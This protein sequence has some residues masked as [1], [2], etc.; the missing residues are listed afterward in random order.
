MLPYLPSLPLILVIY[1][2]CLSTG[3]FFNTI[4]LQAFSHLL[5]FNILSFEKSRTQIIT[6]ENITSEELLKKLI[7][8]HW[9]TLKP[10][11]TLVQRRGRHPKYLLQDASPDLSLRENRKKTVA[12]YIQN[13]HQKNN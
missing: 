10:R 7:Y 11:Q 9:Q 3:I 5:P 13:R 2:A 4:F 12:E 8:Q 6:Q 1:S